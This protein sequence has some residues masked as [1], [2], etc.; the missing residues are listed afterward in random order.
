[1]WPFPQ[2]HKKVLGKSSHKQNTNAKPR[3]ER[4]NPF[5]FQTPS[6]K[7]HHRPLPPLPGFCPFAGLLCSPRDR[8]SPVL[9][10][11]DFPTLFRRDTLPGILT[12][13]LWSLG[14][15]NSPNLSNSKKTKSAL[16]PGSSPSV[17][18]SWKGLVA[19]DLKGFTAWA[20]SQAHHAP[21]YSQ[22]SLTLNLLIH[23]N[24]PFS[25]H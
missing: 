17:I 8:D 6:D 9:P 15:W 12:Q 21:V 4:L 16:V 22:T 25:C 18:F 19:G 20:E 24:S 3:T 13:P 1:M 5:T 11:A 10:E 2:N 14:L 7:H 23:V